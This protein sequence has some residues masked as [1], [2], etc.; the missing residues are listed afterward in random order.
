MT[1]QR[2]HSP[3][4]LRSI[5]LGRLRI[6]Y[7]VDGVMTLWPSRFFPSIPPEHWAAHG[8]ELDAAGRVVMSTGGVVV[9]DGPRVLLIDTGWGKFDGEVQ[10][11]HVRCGTLPDSLAALGLAPD[12]IDTV[13]YTHLHVDHVGWTIAPSS[14]E[15]MFPNATHL[16]SDSEWRPYLDGTQTAG[17]PDPAVLQAL[18]SHVR[19]FT[20]GVE[21]FP[22]VTTLITPGHS[23]GHTSY[24][25]QAGG[26]RLVVFGD[27][28]HVP[29]QL[30]HPEWGSAPDTGSDLARAARER[31]LDE[32]RQ[33]GTLGFGFHFADLA[34]G[35]LVGSTH[36]GW[37]W[38]PV[39]TEVIVGGG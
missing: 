29:C 28:F 27:V 10:F 9:E 24:L 11:G 37:A 19:C 18:G 1:A 12:R 35:R 15:L 21:V 32:L 23:P 20:D 26:W 2:K 5:R 22:R 6:S 4:R 14:R 34:F 16:V 25:I 33:P 39:D 36:G 3:A 31:L 30:S 17:A 13:A 38:E 8:D 7:A